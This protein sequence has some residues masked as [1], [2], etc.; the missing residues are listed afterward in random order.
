MSGVDR[1]LVVGP[2]GALDVW[3]AADCSHITRVTSVP[4]M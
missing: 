3:R 2:A 4:R 1:R